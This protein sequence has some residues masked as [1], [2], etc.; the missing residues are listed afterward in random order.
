MKETQD[1]IR[2]VAPSVRILKDVVD[3]SNAKAVYEA[4]KRAN[5]WAR[6][7]VS[8]LVNNAGIVSGKPLLETED[9]KIV[10]TFQV[11]VLAHFWTVKSLL[12]KMIEQ[13]FGHVVTVA[14]IA[15]L[16]AAPKMVDYASSKHGAVGFASGLRKELKQMKCNVTTSLICPA[17][18]K[19]NLF[20]GFEQPF[21]GSLSPDY[22]AQQILD[23][24]KYRKEVLVMPKLADPRLMQAL[25]PSWLVDSIGSALGLDSSMNNIDL[26]QANKSMSMIKSKL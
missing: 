7:Y 18:I 2:K 15:G 8:I 16:T 25:M 24:V 19:T 4:A 1:S 20:K 11:N 5:A 10:K 21:V 9:S 3:V 14:S 12:P 23:A 6:T 17:H 26:T 22:V 13:N